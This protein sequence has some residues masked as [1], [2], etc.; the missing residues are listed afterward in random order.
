MPA[1]I[2][3]QVRVLQSVAT[4]TLTVWRGTS[5]LHAATQPAQR[6]RLYDM[7]GSPACRDVREALTAL[8]LDAEIYPCPDGGKRYRAQA[9]QIGG[10]KG[11][12]LHLPLLVDA[13]TNTTLYG[14]ARIVDYLFRTYGGRNTPRAYRAGTL[15]PLLGG[16]SHADSGGPIHPPDK[17][18]PRTGARL[19]SRLTPASRL[20][21]IAKKEASAFQR[22]PA[23]SSFARTQKR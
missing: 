19:C 2:A 23:G 11:G 5:V 14:S 9:K 17:R 10:H 20:T 1:R 7:E 18:P 16:I 22:P 21:R 4:S 12:K 3:H 15:R 6:L 13:N 8:G